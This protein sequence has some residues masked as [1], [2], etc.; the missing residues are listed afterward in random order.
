MRHNCLRRRKATPGIKNLVV[1]LLND[2]LSVCP[3][4]R[5]SVDC[6]VLSCHKYEGSLLFYDALSKMFI[7]KVLKETAFETGKLALVSKLFVVVVKIINKQNVL[8]VLKIF[9]KIYLLNKI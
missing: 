3:S 6:Y 7:I 8:I 9:F 2:D 5:L 1:L 4:V